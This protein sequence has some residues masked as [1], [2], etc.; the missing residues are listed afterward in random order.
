MASSTESLRSQVSNQGSTP[1]ETLVSHLLASKR[2]LS[3]I[4]FVYR[5]NELVTAT[6]SSLETSVIT[7]ARTEFLRSGIDSQVQILTRVR[8]NTEDVAREGAAEFKA[9]IRDLD[10]AEKRLRETLNLLR[11]TMVEASLRP[12]EEG[13]RSLLDFVDE[14]GVAGLMARIKA[15]IDTASG[16]HDEF[17][18]T[19]MAFDEDVQSVKNLLATKKPK[20]EDISADGVWETRSPIPEILH[21]MEEHAKDMADNLESLVRHFDL[22][23]TA[24]KHTEGGGD[25]A[26]RIAGEL[27][28]GVDIGQDGAN[29]PAV[30][31]GE[32]ERREMMEVL[33]KDASQVEDV[34]IEIKEHIVEMEAQHDLMTAY[35][36]QLVDEHANTTSA[37]K[38]LEDIGLRLPGYIAQSHVFVMRW[39]DEK[40]KIEERMDEL[41]E[42]RVFY[43]G[44][45]RAYDNLLIE[46]GR[47]KALET[48]ME[49]VAQDAMAR[50]HQLYEDDVEE[51]ESFKKAQGDFL[52][53]DI[54]PGLM[55]GPLQYEILPVGSGAGK[56]PDVSK[57]VILQAI[58]RVDGKES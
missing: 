39:D 51:R 44:F 9:V 3:S 25:A 52:P 28:E 11:E 37:F 26:Q 29:A 56:V 17:S 7:S 36:D 32:D 30:P 12:E 6:R 33:E 53:V 35:T 19:N 48:R 20:Q 22:C 13:K 34:V 4:N 38:L 49:K 41:E 27:P 21:D 14:T 46:I 47:R 2:S 15:S 55:A 1:L 42:L 43:D 8:K 18:E 5:A 57:S 16:A 24:I 45:L 40:A 23:V 10:T 50:I 54:W 31:I 58:R